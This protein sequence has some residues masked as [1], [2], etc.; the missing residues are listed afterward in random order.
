MHRFIWLTETVLPKS[1]P[2]HYFFIKSLNLGVGFNVNEENFR[3]EGE[4]EKRFQQND[5]LTVILTH[6]TSF[7]HNTDTI[8]NN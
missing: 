5:Y 6:S 2:E 4:T 8:Y 7:N 3:P 1:A